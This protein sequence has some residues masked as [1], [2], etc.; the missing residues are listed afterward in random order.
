MA[1]SA[2][3]AKSREWVAPQPALIVEVHFCAASGE[4]LRSL[5][6]DVQSVS[7]VFSPDGRS[8]LASA[9][10]EFRLFETTDSN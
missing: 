3:R 4:R 6:P 2:S 10:R 9:G 1:G 8:L 7:A 5:W